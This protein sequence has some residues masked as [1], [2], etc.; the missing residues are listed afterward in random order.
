MEICIDIETLSTKK[1]AHILSIG[2][3]AFDADTDL[4]CHPAGKVSAYIFDIPV[5]SEDQVGRD[6]DVATVRWWLQQSVSAQ[7][8]LFVGEKIYPL[9]YVLQEL[10]RFIQRFDKPS[11]WANSPSFD[12]DILSDAYEQLGLTRPWKYYQERDV[13]TAKQLVGE[14]GFIGVKHCALDDAV[15]EARIV[16]RYLQLEV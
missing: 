4:N 16:Q 14:P 3:V 9:H 2:A 7:E 10:Q 11:I 5:T 1:N 8:N 13:R 12:C 15:H 6:V